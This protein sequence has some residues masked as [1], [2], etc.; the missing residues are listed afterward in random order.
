MEDPRDAEI[1]ALRQQ[2]ADLRREKDEHESKLRASIVEAEDRLAAVLDAAR[3]GVWDFDV[4]TGTGRW[5][6][7]CHKLYGTDAASFAPTVDSWLGLVHPAD[8]DGVRKAVERALARGRDLNTEFRVPHPAR[9]Q[10]WLWEHGHLEHDPTGRPVRMAGITVDVTERKNNEEVLRRSERLYRGIGESIDYGIWVCDATGRNIYASQSFLDLLGITQRECSEFGW[11]DALHPDDADATIQAWKTCVASGTLWEREHRFRGRDGAW[12][13][14]LARGVP[15][16]DD[17]GRI[18]CWAGIN[19]DIS[20]LKQAEEAIKESD[21]RKDEFLAVLAHEL[22]NPLAPLVMALQL[23]RT[24]RDD[25][26][27]LEGLYRT[28]ER[29][30]R[31]M[32]RLIDDL[33]D[34][35]RISKGKIELRRE[36]VLLADIVEAAIETSRPLIEAGGHQLELSLPGAPVVVAVDH[37]RIAQVL[38]NLLNNSAKYSDRPGVIRLRADCD[39]ER[40]RLSVRD[41]GIGIAPA[42]LSRVFDLFTQADRRHERSRGGLGIGLTLARTLVELH[43]GRVEAFSDGPGHGSEFV[44]TLPVLPRLLEGGTSEPPPPVGQMISHRVLVADDNE[45]AAATLALT[46]ESLGHVVQV[47]Y[48][49]QDALDLARRFQPSVMFL[50]LGMPGLSGLDV[51]RLVR[52]ERWKVAPMLVAITGWGRDDDKRQSREAGFDLHLVKPVDRRAVERVLAGTESTPADA[53]G[54]VPQSSA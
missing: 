45:D 39:G 19:L 1:A 41:S 40:I 38:A 35:S 26:A 54:S 43:G 9:G 16:R 4:V 42:M 53:Q 48:N 46:V 27:R 2:L 18:A 37:M 25:P 5:S 31:Q 3:A 15:I 11:G 12:H 13:H 21:R 36:P 14:I 44:V 33:L 29:Q 49:G 28:M 34:V 51:A 30:L 52:Q 17:D 47:A 50:D 10:I 24:S 32:V 8:R 6:E 22:R 23:A 7:Q 20:R